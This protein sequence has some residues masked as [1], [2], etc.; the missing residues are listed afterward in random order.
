MNDFNTSAEDYL[1]NQFKSNISYTKRFGNSPF[2][3]TANASHTQNSRDSTVTVTLPQVALTMSRIFPFKRKVPVGKQK[4]YEKIGVSLTSNFRNT[5][6][7][8]Q[9]VFFTQNTLDNMR[10]GFRHTIPISTS[11]KAGNFTISPSVNLN[12][13]WYFETTRQN[14]DTETGSVVFDTVEAFRRYGEASASVSLATKLYGMYTYKRGRLKAIRHTMTPNVSFSY[15]PDQSRLNPQYFDSVQ[16][17]ADGDKRR[18]SIFDR[19]IYGGPST[20]RR[21][22]VNFNIQNTLEMKYRPKSDTAETLKKGK[23]LD[24]FNFSSNYD[25]FKDSLNWAPVSFN[26]RTSF[27]RF[28]QLRFDATFDPYALDGE[29]RRINVSE[30]ETTGQLFRLTRAQTSATFRFASKPK[31]ERKDEERAPLAQN[32]ELNDVQN[33]QS[34]YVDFNVPWSLNVNYNITYTKP[35]LESQIV[36]SLTFNGDANVT[37]NW[38]V[39]FRSGY[40]FELNELTYTSLDIFR[41]LHCWQIRFSAIPFGPRTSYTFDI[42]VKASV[43]QDLKLSRRRSW[44]DTN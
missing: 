38:K 29:G 39:G 41:D 31:D 7:A 5:A 25:I 32:N 8:K 10:N 43:L 27:G 6:S 42:H 4:F 2:T 12:E 16:T 1:S 14:F 28:L 19:G 21:A 13:T 17:N 23:I 15:T 26:T 11:L 40:D 18:Y 36:N 30:Y 33:R 34:A 35:G 22:I 20:Y 24:A 44:F 37:D 9:D 3:L